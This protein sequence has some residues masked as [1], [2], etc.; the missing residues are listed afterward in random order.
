MLFKFRI[1]SD[2]VKDF[3]R[4]IVAGE[5][6]TFLDLHTTIQHD[7]DYDPNQLASFFLTNQ[8]WEKEL[9]ITLIDMMDENADNCITMDEAGLGQYLCN[10]GDRMLYVYDF[11]SERAFFI[12]L[13]E[14]IKNEEK[15]IKPKVVFCNGEPPVQ[16]ELGLDL[17]IDPGTS[18]LDDLDNNTDNSNDEDL[19]DDSIDP[20]N[21]SDE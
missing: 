7:L 14:I 4:E 10:A 13:T 6:N 8:Q 2:E 9:E 11:F 3:A 17:D 12:E 5:G 19:T 1:I 15:K 20:D 18:L 16:T 21:V